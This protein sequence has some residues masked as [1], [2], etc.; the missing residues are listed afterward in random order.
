M[1]DI[2]IDEID[3]GWSNDKDSNKI[4]QSLKKQI[5]WQDGGLGT[6]CYTVHVSTGEV[7]H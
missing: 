7:T 5:S 6:Q 2:L 4:F 1:S 3:T